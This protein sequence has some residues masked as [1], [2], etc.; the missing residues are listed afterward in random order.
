MTHIRNHPDPDASLQFLFR[1]NE[2]MARVFQSPPAVIIRRVA[3]TL[4]TRQGSARLLGT[5]A[6]R[7]RGFRGSIYTYLGTPTYLLPRKDYSTLT[8][9]NIK[10]CLVYLYFSPCSLSAIPLPNPASTYP[11]LYSR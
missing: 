11:V 1:K 8:V 7:V 3:V 6:G 5:E 10:S 4:F 2:L 9:G